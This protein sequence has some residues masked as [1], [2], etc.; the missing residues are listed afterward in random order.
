[1]KQSIDFMHQL[2][3]HIVWNVRLR[4]FLDKGQCITEDEAVSSE[5]C[6]LG[7]WLANEGLI[8]YKHITQIKELDA[9]HVQM[10]KQVKKIIAAKIA[11][12]DNNAEA[13][14][15]ILQKISEKIIELLTE[16][17]QIFEND[18]E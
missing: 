12:E 18:N 10:H 9:V 15:I 6:I 14:M 7:Q 16:L 17:D 5:K 11:G 13:G 1:M 8:N 3:E 2:T 4:C